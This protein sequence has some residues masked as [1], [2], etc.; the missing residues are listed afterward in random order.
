MNTDDKETASLSLRIDCEH[1]GSEEVDDL[2]QF[3]ISSNSSL[4]IEKSFRVKTRDSA[5]EY[6]ALLTGHH[7][8][9]IFFL[10][11]VGT[12]AL[13]L[14]KDI[15][16]DFLQDLIKQWIEKRRKSQEYELVT[17]YGPSDEPVKT[18]K[19]FKKRNP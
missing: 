8:L 15:T 13:H 4:K 10:G 19:I 3:L 9:V 1:L 14:T 7:D 6:H 16:K 12:E 17:L 18:V 11:A 2:R 5:A